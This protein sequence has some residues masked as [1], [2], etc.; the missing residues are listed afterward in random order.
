MTAPDT[1]VP[2]GARV[3]GPRAGAS[4]PARPRRRRRSL[5]GYAF[6]AGY[7]VLLAAYGIGPTLYS[8]YLALTDVDGRF[9]GL[10][11]F[12][13]IAEDFRYTPA[14]GHVA[15]YLAAW[16]LSLVIIVVGL[17]LML[18]HIAARGTSRVLRFVYYI[19][20]ALAGAAS[21]LV[22]LFMLDPTT[23]PVGFLLRWIGY[24]TFGQVIAP[25]HLPVLF[26]II[27]FWT[28]AGGWIV[29][30]HGALNNISVDILDAARIDG[31]NG[32]QVA[33]RIQLPLLRKWI[34]YM[35]ILAFAG[36]TQLFVEPLADPFVHGRV[37]QAGQPPPPDPHVGHLREPG[38]VGVVDV[39][40]H[41]G[42]AV[43]DMPV[44]HVVEEQ[45]Q[46]VG[47]L[48]QRLV[49]LGPR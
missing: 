10:T 28:G 19:P 1:V 14:I 4:G 26:A 40:D 39:L 2:A 43:Q 37:D 23:S 31:A 25:G 16:M 21:V 17:A 3:R 49:R 36:G 22:W 44:G 29:V 15:A 27:A 47:A 7:V 38:E 32:W 46:L 9:A 45:Q 11:N 34:A 48:V 30:L 35:L 18:H 6:V 5:A 41:G 20:G 13:Q 42:S 12:T 24:D 8:I 33:R